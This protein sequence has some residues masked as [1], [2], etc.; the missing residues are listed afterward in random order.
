MKGKPFCV[1][2]GTTVYRS[3]FYKNNMLTMRTAIPFL[4]FLNKANVLNKREAKDNTY[5]PNCRR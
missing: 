1:G 4:L 3:L 5:T 2:R